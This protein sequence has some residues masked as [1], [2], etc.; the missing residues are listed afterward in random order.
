M[1]GLIL[2]AWFVV[3]CIVAI[4]LVRPALKRTTQRETIG[5]LTST[6]AFLGGTGLAATGRLGEIVD[7]LPLMVAV[8][9]AIA[10]VALVGYAIYLPERGLRDRLRRRR[11]R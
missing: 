9:V 2:Y 5:R 11:P 8:G 7:H 10:D 4:A 1:L 6:L 3:G